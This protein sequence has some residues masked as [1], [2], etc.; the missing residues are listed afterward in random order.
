MSSLS[1][2]TLEAGAISRHTSAG[3]VTFCEELEDLALGVG[4]GALARTSSAEA[5]KLGPE[6]SL[7]SA[8]ARKV[9]SLVRSAAASAEVVD[10]ESFDETAV[11]RRTRSAEERALGP[12]GSSRRLVLKACAKLKELNARE[13][14]LLDDWKETRCR[15]TL[16]ASSAGSAGSR[17][18]VDSMG[19][20]SSFYRSPYSSALTQISTERR[21]AKWL[22]GHADMPRPP[23]IPDS[24]LASDSD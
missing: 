2:L 7:L 16:S 17:S 12:K 20:S 23:S 22:R 6:G 18:S 1:H 19:L 9:E 10:V 15:R 24:F 11:A 14:K 8:V 21:H 13:A 4:A 3:S 5:V